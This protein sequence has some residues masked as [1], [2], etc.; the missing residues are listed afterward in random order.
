LRNRPAPED[1]YPVLRAENAQVAIAPADR[2]YGVLLTGGQGSGKSA[3]LLALYLNDCEDPDAAPLVIDPKSELSQL[4]LKFTR[5][6][7]GKTV[8]YLDLAHPAFGMNPLRLSGDRPLPVEAGAIADNVVAALLDINTN[9]IF[10]SSRRY[11]Y[12]AVVG[13][14]ALAHRD[15]RRAKF[16]DV[17]NLLLPTKTEIRA[18]VA[19]ACS[20]EPDL[21]QTAEFFA[22]ELPH[23]LQLAGSATAQR[24]DAPRNK[25]SLLL[26][27]PSLR[28]WFSHPT[29]IPLREIID[30]RD[31]LLID[32][33]MGAIG[34]ENSK[35][36]MHFLLRLL[37][38]QMQLQVHLPETDR[39]R[40]PLLIDEAHYVMG[41]ENVIDQ[42]ATHR[43]AG[44]EPA[45]AIQYFS[46]LG[47]GSEHAEKIR[48]GVLNLL[49]S[50]LLFRIG[51]ADD[52]EQATRIAM[53][54][55]STMIHDDPDS[56]ARLRVTPEQ[57]L[58]FPNYHCLASWIA[59]GTRAPCFI[60]QTYPWATDTTDAW[61]EHH[62]ARQTARVAPYPERLDSTLDRTSAAA[63]DPDTPDS[64][65]PKASRPAGSDSREQPSAKREVQVDYEPP[66]EPPRLDDSPVRRVVGRRVPGP[67]PGEH[68]GPAPDSLRELAFLDRINEISPA[69]QLDGAAN[70]PR[71][72]N[73]DYALLALLDRAGLAPRS[74]IGRAVLPDRAPRTVAHRLTKLYRHGLIAQ[75][76]TG[77]AGHA[78]NDGTPPLL[79]SLTRRGLEVAQTREPPAISR[80]REWRAIEQS[81]AGRLAHDLHA[82]A[83]AIELHRIA[84]KLATDHWRTARYA[85]GRYP[86]PQTGSGRDRHPITL[87][88]I[89]L[90]DKQ[91]I[92]D[93]QLKSFTELHPDL[94]LELKVP[95]INLTFDLLVE[96]D[97][98]SRPS[99]NHDKFLAYD[100][101]LCGW[102]LAQP[103]YRAHGTRPAVIFLCPDARA[104][105]A[106]AREADQALSG[107]IGIMGTPAEHWYY[108]GRDH[109]FIAVE[110]DIHHY[111]LSALALPPQPPGLR[112]RLTGQ[113]DL[114]LTPVQLLPDKLLNH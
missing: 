2:K 60:G 59:D 93:L 56:R 74:L 104:A 30:A 16:E 113:R 36:C 97:L 102:S 25:V 90:G 80:K 55:Y 65:P 20:D 70:L 99:Y 15:D 110:G 57:L 111:S 48:K 54:V 68:D 33:N 17:Y 14:I 22:Y 18:A 96:L 75:H 43:R 7:C 67:A 24:L 50:R 112:E 49:Q 8:W 19:E 82:L 52:A 100:A 88:E 66:P 12:H 6:E 23:E 32:A 61:A 28:R 91:A 87:N 107:R 47:S 40:V 58:N 81:N 35:A 63:T 21:D 37:H 79:Y 11:L 46:Q 10:Q 45:C 105:L 64:K 34:E 109:T 26:Q 41:A 84:G 85:T 78:Q 92:I 71:L 86:V 62:V 1:L 4:C 38:T 76:P 42:F 73:E 108:P 69:D 89:P 44:L 39:P 51:D 77:L 13:A 83:W 95:T 31:V 9:Q 53:A 72:Y 98:T 29:D 101:F 106:L 94:S 5:P 3:A 103:R 27:V 114:E